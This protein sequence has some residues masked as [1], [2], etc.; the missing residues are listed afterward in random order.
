ML[1]LVELALSSYSHCLCWVLDLWSPRGLLLFGK[2]TISAMGMVIV[3]GLIELVIVV[4]IKI[5]LLLVLMVSVMD[6]DDQ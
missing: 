5:K 1:V 3:I 6:G 4:V 2:I